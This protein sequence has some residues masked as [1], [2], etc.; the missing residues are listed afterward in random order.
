VTIDGSPATAFQVGGRAVN[1]RLAV[2]FF[3]VPAAFLFL[4]WAPEPSLVQQLHEVQGCFLAFPLANLIVE[5][6]DD[7]AEHATAEVAEVTYSGTALE[8]FIQSIKQKV[9]AKEIC[10]SYIF[11]APNP[12]ISAKLEKLGS[13][14]AT[15]FRAPPVEPFK[16]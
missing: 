2:D 11:D 14:S 15:S 12:T 7:A 6:M 1:S 8:P 16:A 4:S 9:R 5:R 3:E 10:N 13:S